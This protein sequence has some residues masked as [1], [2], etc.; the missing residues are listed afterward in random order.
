MTEREAEIEA[1]KQHP[2]F[3]AQASF[4]DGKFRVEL[5][6]PPGDFGVDRA[7]GTF[8]ERDDSLCGEGATFEEALADLAMRRAF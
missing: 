8:E 4:I 2:G 7:A 5:T 6:P 1:N 3:A